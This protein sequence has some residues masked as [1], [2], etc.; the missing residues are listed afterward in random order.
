[1]KGEFTDLVLRTL[2]DE[3]GVFEVVNGC[4]YAGTFDYH[5]PA[6]TKTD[7]ASIPRL[8]RGVFSRTGRS[9]KPAV[10]HDHMYG[11]QWETRKVCDQAFREMLLA[12]GV[13]KWVANVYY[14]GVRTGG[15][16]RGTKDTREWTW[17]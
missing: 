9:R 12:R 14:L 16:T 11:G 13:G 2:D 4:N 1:M 6:G 8:M 7:L 5:V 3:P 10:F 17:N 15:W